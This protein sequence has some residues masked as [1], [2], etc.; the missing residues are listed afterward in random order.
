MTHKKPRKPRKERQEKGSN[1]VNTWRERDAGLIRESQLNDCDLKVIIELL[2]KQPYS[3]EAKLLAGYFLKDGVLYITDDDEQENLV[4]PSDQRHQL[5][6]EFH[7]APTGGHFGWRKMV[8]AMRKEYFWPFM[9][10]E[11]KIYCQMC[12]ACA[13]RNGQGHR[14]R[15]Q[16]RLIPITDEPMER[17]GM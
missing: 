8:A 7:N 14:P 11:I 4:V 6:W 1:P 15:P 10:R 12:Q 2:E 17:V 16:L 13:A 3:T 9:T 5:M